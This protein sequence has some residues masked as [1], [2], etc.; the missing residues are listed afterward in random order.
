MDD[1]SVDMDAAWEQLTR[2]ERWVVY[3]Y[4][5]HGVKNEAAR[6]AGKSPKWLEYHWRERAAF[7]KAMQSRRWTLDTLQERMRVQL[8]AEGHV[9]LIE[10]FMTGKEIPSAQLRAVKVAVGLGK[11]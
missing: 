9:R 8:A 3:A 11:R 4:R 7:R 5:T 1:S 6:S 2:D 10:A